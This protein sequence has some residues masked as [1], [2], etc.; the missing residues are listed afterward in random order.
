MPVNRAD[1][2]ARIRA[3]FPA[4]PLDF[5]RALTGGLDDGAY[6]RHVDGTTWL[7]LE[8]AYVLSRSDVLSFLQ[9]AHLVGVLPVYLRSLVEDG[10]STP[11]PDTLLLVLDPASEPRFDKIYRALDDAQRAVVLAVLQWFAATQSGAPAEAARRAS[12]RWRDGRGGDV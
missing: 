3:A 6:R 1:L 8:R 9:P 10:T 2:V 7:E 5:R 12:E 11:V 4:V